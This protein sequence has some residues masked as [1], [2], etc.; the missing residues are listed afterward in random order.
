MK[1]APSTP[2]ANPLV[3]TLG[4]AV[5]GALRS[6]TIAL[7]VLLAVNSVA[8][9]TLNLMYETEALR[10][11]YY[12][13]GVLSRNAILG[14]IV[15]LLYLFANSRPS[16]GKAASDRFS[17]LKAKALRV[18]AWLTFLLI[19]IIETVILAEN[20]LFH[21]TITLVRTHSQTLNLIYSVLFGSIAVILLVRTR[22]GRSGQKILPA[23]LRSLVTS[24]FWRGL[25]TS[26]LFSFFFAIIFALGAFLLYKT[27]IEGQSSP[28]S[29]L[30][31]HFPVFAAVYVFAGLLCGGLAG[32]IYG[33]RGK[34]EEVVRGSYSLAEPFVKSLLS[35][36]SADELTN[37]ESLQRIWDR[38]K[39][40]AGEQAPGLLGKLMQTRFLRSVQGHW[41]LDLVNQFKQQQAAGATRESLENLLGEKI[42]QLTTEDIRTRLGLLQWANYAL[43]IV[44]LLSPALLFVIGR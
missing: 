1:S 5:W 10:H 29:F 42:I 9:L 32:G 11:R 33:I 18:L 6:F 14:I 21:Q 34:A 19:A 37:H 7:F 2:R 26:A 3:E 8:I 40:L 13:P 41:L 36:V 39:S 20:L 43:A 38:G 35:K 30:M 24:L 28:P 27:A 15:L 22:S 44:L 23:Q 4:L 31:L 25:K 17:S 12:W 16:I